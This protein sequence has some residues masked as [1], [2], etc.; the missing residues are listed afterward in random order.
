MPRKIWQSRVEYVAFRVLHTFLRL[1]PF[2]LADWTLANLTAFAGRLGL[3]RKTVRRNMRIAFPEWDEARLRR[4][5]RDHYRHVGHIIAETYLWPGNHILEDVE[6]RYWENLEKAMAMEKGVVVVSMH[7][8]N[9]EIGGRYVAWRGVRPLS[10]VYKPLRNPW[11]D[12]FTADLR[13]GEG[14]GQIPVK[15]SLRPILGV[16]RKKG[17]MVFLSD[18]NAGSDGVRMPFFGR[19]ASVHTGPARIALKTGSPI[20]CIFGMR[21]P[22]GK[23]I[24]F[25]E[26]PILP[27]GGDDPASIDRLTRKLVERMEER[28][29]AC[30]AQWLWMHNRWK[31]PSRARPLASEEVP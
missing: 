31:N 25:I 12:K 3:R 15:G 19:D 29:N 5:M 6:P 22:D 14:I 7:Y 27:E 4:E 28:I 18:Q 10:V 9:W 16:L 8:G 11:V 24:L 1:L 20:V 30:P 17:V 21:K 2:R 23:H 13:A 26:E